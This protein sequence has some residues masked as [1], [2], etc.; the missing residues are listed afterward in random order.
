MEW[1]STIRHSVD[2]K[3]MVRFP[4]KVLLVKAEMLQ[5]EYLVSC[6]KNDVQPE[7][8]SITPDWINGV[9]WEYRIT[10]RQP[11]RKYKV[12]RWVLAEADAKA[13][14]R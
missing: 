2:C 1:Y 11:N 14:H 3:L 5:Q 8:V 7:S 9:L 6:L 13:W 10:H 4:K 12:A